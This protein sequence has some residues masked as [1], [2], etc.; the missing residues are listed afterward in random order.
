M[1]GLKSLAK[2]TAIYGMSSIVGRF[3][4]Y[5][6]VPL[7]TA[8]IPSATGGYGVVSNVYAY[9]ALILVL[10]TFGMET[11]FFR[12]ANKQEEDA[13]KVYANSLIFIGGLSLLFV[14]LCM[15]FLQPISNLLEY[16]DHT[17]YIAMMIL[18]VALDSFQCIPFAYLRYQKR[19][20]KFAAIKL[21]NIVGNIGL[22][23]FFLL[24]CPYLY[25]HS[26]ELVSWF[27][28][29]DY[30]VGYIFVSNLIMSVL[31]MFFFIPELKCVTYR[32]DPVLMKR[33]IHYSFPILIFGL[34]G[35]LNQTI[36]KM[37]YPFLFDDRQEGLVQLGIYSATSKVAMVMAMFTQAF[38][39]AYEPFVFGKNKEKDSKK[40]YSAAMKYFFIFA[41]L[42]F[43]AVMFY[44]D[45]LKYL[46]ASDYR[47][48]LGVVAI[49]M[50]AEI[51]K[52]I[53]FNL[54]FWYKLTDETYWG[55]Y[56]SLIGCSVILA[57]NVWLVPTYGYVASAWASVAGY[58]VITLLSYVIGQRKYPVSYPL[59][60]M[61]MYLILA[62]LLFGVAYGVHIENTLLR[63][64]FRSLLL[65]VFVGYIIR[66][67]L[68]LKSI[69]LLNRFVKS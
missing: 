5:L 38:R 12:F 69:P 50:G 45:I 60:A 18:V 44:M 7:Y 39:Y 35:I 8:V 51:L 66:K 48:G 3:L 22:N 63:L 61:G 15:I 54:S 21:L 49:V 41:L 36:D 42:A 37:I 65:L 2:D 32:V 19:P 56:F 40:M 25:R 17:D 10:L 64:V 14:V 29:P 20:I 13:G 58:G 33:M 6:L 31:Q 47:E 26:P 53:Y 68:P 16:P 4:N 27:Y 23:L 28:N 52:G 43:L 67:D 57:L 24:L 1:A 59:G 46:V 34:V 11:G 62:A 30:L 9:T 55:A